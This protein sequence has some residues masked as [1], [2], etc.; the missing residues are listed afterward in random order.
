M[1]ERVESRLRKLEDIAQRDTSIAYDGFWEAL[2]FDREG[3]VERQLKYPDLDVPMILLSA[4][5]EE[6]WADGKDD[7]KEEWV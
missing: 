4:L 1:T 2:G 5:A 6:S 7:S 3:V